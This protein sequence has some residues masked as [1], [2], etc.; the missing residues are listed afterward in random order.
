MTVDKKDF[1]L[2]YRKQLKGSEDYYDEK[3]KNI[4]YKQLNFALCF[5]RFFRKNIF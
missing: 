1:I 5:W 4:T 3:N 2:D